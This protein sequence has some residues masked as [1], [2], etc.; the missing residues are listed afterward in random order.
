MASLVLAALLVATYYAG[1]PFE[2]GALTF[3]AAVVSAIVLDHRRGVT[4][5]TS[6]AQTV[7]YRIG[8]AFTAML[9]L[10]PLLFLLFDVKA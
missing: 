4:V 2:V 8:M 6:P 5:P 10:V 7:I 3:F 1:L 9:L